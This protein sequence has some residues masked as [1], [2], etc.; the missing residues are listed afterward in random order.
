MTLKKILILSANPINTSQLRL[1]EEVREIDSGLRRAKHRDKFILEQRWATRPR[2]LRQALL[3]VRPNIVHF[4]G[5]G[6]TDGIMLEDTSNQSKLISSIAL[7]GLFELFANSVECVLLNA[8]YSNN[9]AEGISRHID[10]V[11][12]MDNAIGDKAAIEFAVGFY[13]ALGAGESYKVA[14][15]FGFN[16][17]LL[18]GA[19]E[20]CRPIL[21]IK[22]DKY[23]EYNEK[24][25]GRNNS[26]KNISLPRS[27]FKEPSIGMEFLKVPKG[28]F[29]MGDNFGM[30]SESE[31]PVHEVK[32]NC[33]HLGKYPIT[34]GQWKSVMKSNPSDFLKGDDYPVENVSWNEA[35]EFISKISKMNE[36][37]YGFRLPTEAEWEYAARSGGKI[38]KFSGGNDV[39]T[40]AWYRENSNNSTHLVGKKIPNGIGLYD[41]SGNVYEWCEDSYERNIYYFHKIDNPINFSSSPFANMG[42]VARGGSWKNRAL[43]VRCSR[44][45]YF[46]ANAKENLLGF[47]LAL[48]L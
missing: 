12:G 32:I 30:G 43:H 24:T 15:K 7:S 38:E 22:K 45:N 42:K 44:R 34:Q 4:S 3:D 20:K 10:Y 5:H 9:Q 13:D 29:K 21:T 23:F 48:D 41:M 37:K 46:S 47:R 11:L 8:C 36:N 25:S 28:K 6:T 2:D 18:S 16:A 39:D 31:T 33:F 35:K 1:D 17:I 40:L 14:Y 19:S 26:D 27:S